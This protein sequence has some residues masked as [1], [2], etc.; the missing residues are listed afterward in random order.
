MQKT[1][2]GQSGFLKLST[3]IALLFAQQQLVSFWSRFCLKLTHRSVDWQRNDRLG[4]DSGALASI[5][6]PVA[7]YCVQFGPRPTPTPTLTPTSTPTVTPTA[8]PPPTAT[9]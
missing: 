9:P 5:W 6:A 8:S 2:T 3:L 1:S 4:A 7:R